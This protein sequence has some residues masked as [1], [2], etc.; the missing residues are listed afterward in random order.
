MYLRPTATHHSPNPHPNLLEPSSHP[1]LPSSPPIPPDPHTD[2]PT[3]PHRKPVPPYRPSSPR[4]RCNSFGTDQPRRRLAVTSLRRRPSAPSTSPAS[5]HTATSP[6]STKSGRKR[7]S[8]D[9]T[10]RRRR[11][12][13]RRRSA[14]PARGKP[15]YVSTIR[16]PLFC[17]HRNNEAKNRSPVSGQALALG[18][19]VGG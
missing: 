1:S 2:T 19:G 6:R 17:R 12:R 18:G 14:R 10:V 8:H 7:R 15:C 13:R 16:T 4:R 9:G 3:S 11:R 5:A